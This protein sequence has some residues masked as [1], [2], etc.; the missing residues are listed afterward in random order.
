[1]PDDEIRHTRHTMASKFLDTL[2]NRQIDPE[3]L[4]RN[5]EEDPNLAHELKVG[6]EP[7]VEVTL[8]RLEFEDSVAPQA[9][10]VVSVPV[11]AF[12]AL[13]IA[14]GEQDA[15]SQ[16]N[17]SYELLSQ[18]Y[19]YDLSEIG[20]ADVLSLGRYLHN[21]FNFWLPGERTEGNQDMATSRDHGLV[22]YN[23]KTIFYY[24]RGTLITPEMADIEKNRPQP[25]E[26]GYRHGSLRGSYKNNDPSQKIQD[27]A[28]IWD[29]K[30]SINMGQEF[31]TQL[32]ERAPSGILFRFEIRYKMFTPQ[33]NNA[34]VP[35][36]VGSGDAK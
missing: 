35:I 34:S 36:S 7:G 15:I 8:Y 6:K 11:N 25:R 29:E 2:L 31:K 30:D 14:V 5:V 28:I 22:I 20:R 26:V 32:T 19:L 27:R 4:M 12:S 18:K 10:A 16:R 13:Q 17:W 23:G 3:E 9:G 21:D 24:D 1:M 33:G